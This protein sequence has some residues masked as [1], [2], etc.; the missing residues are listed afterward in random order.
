MEAAG[1]LDGQEVSYLRSLPFAARLLVMNDGSHT[2]TDSALKFFE[3]QAG[4]G[5]RCSFPTRR[6]PALSASADWTSAAR[7]A[8]L[9]PLRSGPEVR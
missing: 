3:Q 6:S 7:D 2:C 9:L 8:E 4:E 5:G 1:A